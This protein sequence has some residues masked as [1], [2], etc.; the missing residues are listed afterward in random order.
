MPGEEGVGRA[1]LTL[2]CVFVNKVS[3]RTWDA[4]RALLLT[5]HSTGVATGRRAIHS[6]SHRDRVDLR[7]VVHIL[8]PLTNEE[9]VIFVLP[10]Q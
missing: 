1:L 4:G 6:V 8:T 2:V 5:Y 7:Y 10:T 3:G 9:N